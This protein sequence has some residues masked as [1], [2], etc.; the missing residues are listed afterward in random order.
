[1]DTHGGR[2][3]L[4][5][6]L[7]TPRTPQIKLLMQSERN[8]FTEWLSGASC[9]VCHHPLLSATWFNRDVCLP[10]WHA[11][12]LNGTH[13]IWMMDSVLMWSEERGIFW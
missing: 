7:C 11:I 2:L 12:P 6:P 10:N 8:M 13:A 1:M 3:D 9:L 5:F 4:R